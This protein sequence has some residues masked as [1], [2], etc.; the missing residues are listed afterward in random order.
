MSRNTKGKSLSSQPS[1]LLNG[2]LRVLKI[3]AANS[4]KLGEN[5]C[6][7]FWNVNSFFVAIYLL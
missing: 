7:L 3:N 6:D 5:S 1:F 4:C 2:D